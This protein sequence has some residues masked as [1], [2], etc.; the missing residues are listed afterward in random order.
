MH[1]FSSASAA[2][3]DLLK[4]ET[5]TFSGPGEKKKQKKVG[6]GLLKR[7]DSLLPGGRGGGGLCSAP[8]AIAARVLFVD[9]LM[10]E[11]RRAETQHRPAKLHRGVIQVNLEEPTVVCHLEN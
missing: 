7:G 5:G 1:A 10:A 6:D 11:A 2:S 8:P 9:V 4:K 3:D